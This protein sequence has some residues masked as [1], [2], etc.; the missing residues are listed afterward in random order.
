MENSC[1]HEEI[2]HDWKDYG[3]ST[4][5]NMGSSCYINSAF[6]CI[7][8]TIPLVEYLLKIPS[9]SLVGHPV[10]NHFIQ[11]LK[12]FW[13]GNWTITPKS[14]TTTM[15]N[16]VPHLNPYSQE[17]SS[18]CIMFLLDLLN[19]TLSTLSLPYSQ[20]SIIRREIVSDLFQGS[21][22]R[23]TQCGSCMSRTHIFTPF[24]CIELP[25]NTQL[26]GSFDIFSEVE[27]LTEYHCESCQIKGDATTQL[28][29][30]KLPEILVVILKRFTISPEGYISKDSRSILIETNLQLTQKS[31]GRVTNYQLY[32]INC[33]V[34]TAEQGHYYSIVLNTD[35][36]WWLFNDEKR[37]SVKDERLSGIIRSTAYVLFFKRS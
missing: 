2:S 5:R 21:Y 29:L 37:S 13:N 12:G 30:W 7:A 20:V 22:Q 32:A 35:D 19:E 11:L 1:R 15:E 6:Q 36:R 3:L 14:F 25:V 4:L 34:G 24:M 18:E 27:R 16:H 31:D 23:E 26:T 9:S 8:H 10:I 28:E 17:D 33:H